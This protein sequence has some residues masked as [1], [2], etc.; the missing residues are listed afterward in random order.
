MDK[1]NEI[2]NKL[3]NFKKAMAQDG[4]KMPNRFKNYKFHYRPVG[5]QVKK[6]VENP[7]AKPETKPE[8]PDDKKA[9]SNNGAANQGG[10]NQCQIDFRAACISEHNKY[11]TM[12][13]APALKGSSSLHASSQSYAQTL[14]ATNSF[15]HSG[16]SGVGENL[17]YSWSSSVKS[18]SN[19]AGLTTLNKLFFL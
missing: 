9:P 6:P 15:K 4:Y 12:H 13:H 2:K 14:A 10:A 7:V 17:A 5:N 18:L 1:W 19:C 8:I 3:N 16:K 11:R